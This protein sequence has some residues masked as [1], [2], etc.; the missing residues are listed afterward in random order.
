MPSC[1]GGEVGR[2]S[3]TTTHINNNNNNNNTA[4]KWKKEKGRPTKMVN[5][6]GRTVCVFRFLFK[7]T[8]QHFKTYE[9]LDETINVPT[10]IQ[11]H[12][13]A[14]HEKWYIALKVN[15]NK[16]IDPRITTI[17]AIVFVSTPVHTTS[18]I[19]LDAVLAKTKQEL[20]D[21]I[22]AC[23]TCSSRW[24]L[25][26]PEEIGVVLTI[27]DSVVLSNYP[28]SFEMPKRAFEHP[29]SQQEKVIFVVCTCTSVSNR[30]RFLK[31]K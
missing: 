17:P 31:S 15:F 3:I 26:S 16:A 25:G 10:T 18:A 30:Q 12:L 19:S 14:Q 11:K 7:K 1:T 28:R 27:Y 21:K 2:N 13:R 9:Q 6:V 22:D 29:K 23:V 20:I 24:V 4:S 5:N 8:G